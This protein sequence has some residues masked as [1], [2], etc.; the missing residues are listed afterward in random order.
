MGA[1]VSH[2]DFEWVYTEE[3]HKTRRKEII[4]T[5]IYE[6]CNFVVNCLIFCSDVLDFKCIVRMITPFNLEI[7]ACLKKLG[8]AH[9][10]WFS[11]YAYLTSVEMGVTESHV[12]TPPT[13]F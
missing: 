2:N 1:T 5:Q 4:G 10:A 13:G 7:F 12:K 11:T 8:K 3:P 9:A 6:L